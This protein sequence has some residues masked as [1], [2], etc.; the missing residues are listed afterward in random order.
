M[1]DELTL[2]DLIEASATTGTPVSS[3]TEATLYILH[4]RAKVSAYCVRNCVEP[5]EGHISFP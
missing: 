3:L 4:K 5:S 1:L 2:E